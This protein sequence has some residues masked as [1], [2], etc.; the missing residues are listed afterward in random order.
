MSPRTT[1]ARRLRRDGGPKDEGS[2][3]LLPQIVRRAAAELRDPQQNEDED[4]DHEHDD[5][6][7]DQTLARL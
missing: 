7:L 3:W 6:E 5:H 2:N 1:K 4:Q